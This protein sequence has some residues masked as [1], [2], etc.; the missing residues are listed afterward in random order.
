MGSIQAQTARNANIRNLDH[1][2][3]KSRRHPNEPPRLSG[4]SSA[5]DDMNLARHFTEAE[6]AIDTGNCVTLLQWRRESG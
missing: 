3:H 2:T 1:T 4:G 5:A 6:K